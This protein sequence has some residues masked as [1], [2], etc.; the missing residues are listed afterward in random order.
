M[1]DTRIYY[2]YT[3][4]LIT[5]L[6]DMSNIHLTVFFS[7]LFLLSIIALTVIIRYFKLKRFRKHFDFYQQV[8]FPD[9]GMVM[10]KGMVIDDTINIMFVKILKEDGKICLIS[11]KDIYPVKK[12]KKLLLQFQK[13]SEFIKNRYSVILK[14]NIV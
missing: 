7:S 8:L 10:R 2:D 4:L 12:N 13:K 5:K 1:T 11:R 6:F 9:T 14:K 3:I